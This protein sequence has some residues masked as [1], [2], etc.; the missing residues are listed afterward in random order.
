MY[1]DEFAAAAE[2]TKRLG[3]NCPNI[4]VSDERFLSEEKMNQF[5][6]ALIDA[7]GEFG[8]RE[9]AAQC[10]SIHHRLLN[11]V[12]AILGVPAYYTIGFVETSSGLLFEQD[13]ESLRTMLESGIPS[14]KLKIH[15]WLSLPSMEILDFSLPTSYAVMN[16]MEEGIGGLILAHADD[17]KH[18]MKYHPMLIG[19]DFLRKTGALIEF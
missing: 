5:P 15:A 16:N 4:D 3:L 17:L 13:E 14:R 8:I 7:V 11:P 9:V 12:S 6:S 19:D 2:R 1:L 10:L 18:G